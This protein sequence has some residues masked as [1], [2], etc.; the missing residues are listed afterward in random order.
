[1]GLKSEK[2]I[3]TIG[4]PFD[5]GTLVEN[6]DNVTVPAVPNGWTAALPNP[7]GENAP[8]WKTVSSNSASSPNAVFAPDVNKPYLAQLES[9]TVPIRV[10]GSK[11]IFKINYNTES[12]WDGTTLDIKIGSGAYRDIAEAGAIFISGEY[13]NLLSGGNFPNAGRRA[14]SGNSNGYVDV[15]ILLPA[16]AQGQ[17]VQFRWNASADTSI[18]YVGTY[19][20]DIKVIN[21]YECVITGTF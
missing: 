15:E 14:W 21:D 7:D 1:M 3:L 4:V 10:S 2:R 8:P 9:P 19:L 11:L 20:D 17:N 12:G 18:A 16:S 5:T 13:S 6:F